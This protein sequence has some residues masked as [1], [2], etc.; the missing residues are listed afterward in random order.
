MKDYNFDIHQEGERH[1]VGYNPE[2]DIR[3]DA[4]TYEEAEIKLREMI[5]LND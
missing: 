4:E 5:E 1:Y 3:V 2:R